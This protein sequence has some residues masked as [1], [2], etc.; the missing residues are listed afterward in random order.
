MGANVST[1][2][3]YAALAARSNGFSAGT[4]VS[5]Q[6]NKA[7]RQSS[8][9]AAT[10]AQ[11]IS[12][13]SGNDV[14]DDGNL[15]TI[16]TNLGLA[17]KAAVAS[18]VP[19]ATQAQ[20]NAG[21]SNTTVVNPKTLSAATQAQ[22][23]T[24][25]TATGSAPSFVLTP[26]P[27]ITAYAAP[28][29]FQV[30]FSAAGGA[31]PT[32]NVSGLGAKNLKQYNSSSVKIPAVI[33]A[34]Q[35]SDIFYDGT[36]F[37]LLDQLPNSTGVTAAQFDS[38]LNLATTAFAQGI[39]FQYSS[40]VLASANITLTTVSH[41]GSVVVGNSSSPITVTLPAVSTAPAKVA[42]KF[43]NYGI[44]TMTISVAGSDTIY[45][46][47]SVTSFA[48]T[49][50]NSITLVSSGAGV[51]FATDNS[52]LGVTAPQFDNSTKPATT[53]FAQGIGYQF[54]GLVLATSTATLTA[55]VHAGAMI[56]GNSSSAITL[57]LPFTSAMPA[58]TA[59]KFWNYGAGTM[60]VQVAGS[61][62]IY[63]PALVT[64]FNVPTGSFIT[65]ASSATGVW[66]A[67]DMS[68]IGVGQT[69]Q[70][71]GGSRVP[72]T[73]YANATGRPLS[74]SINGTSGS[75]GSTYSATV[76]GSVTASTTQAAGTT[77][78]NLSFIVPVG[79]TYSVS[80]GSGSITT[81]WEL[82]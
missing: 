36:D 17:I 44:G 4:A 71:M 33:G 62:A 68:G 79:A 5:K 29:R 32:I 20:V 43:W 30:T 67:V 35:T 69:W 47:S 58:K 80:S 57:T 82:R 49:T 61:D 23:F 27:A 48:V 14:L 55:G 9:M 51:W 77:A 40:L 60:T 7:W 42:I 46:P 45:I 66:Y 22:A 65:L 81:W 38:S 72:G 54:S 39:G 11:F 37:V 18:G 41:A 75:G 31:T 50:G 25:F 15:A 24:A 26:T 59:I 1:Q 2:A 3:E 6:L 64:S 63:L 74:I 13:Q 52:S 12:D 19:Y 16:Q 8:V 53:A 34:G 28:Q 78:V 70:S 10:L 56:V 76:S 73:S 21:S